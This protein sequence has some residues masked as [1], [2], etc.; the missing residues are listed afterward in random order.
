MSTTAMQL[1]MHARM[2]AVAHACLSLAVVSCV[3]GGQTALYKA[4]QRGH[5]A[6]VRVL[7]D[8]GADVEARESKVRGGGQEGA[9]SGV[10]GWGG[11]AP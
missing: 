6:S 7:L 10:Q 8:A 9:A 2:H 3:Q 11:G 4:G 1:H 5:T